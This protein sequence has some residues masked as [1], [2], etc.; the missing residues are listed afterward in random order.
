MIFQAK[1]ERD[2]ICL[3]YSKNKSAERPVK[4]FLGK[5]IAHAYERRK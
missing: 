5:C 1:N 3:L 4:Q 2:N